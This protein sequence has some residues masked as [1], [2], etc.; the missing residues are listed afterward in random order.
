MVH[1]L[2]KGPSG[3]HLER[4][5]RRGYVHTAALAPEKPS[6]LVIAL[7]GAACGENKSIVE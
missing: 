3:L 1:Q 2:M 7:F 5:K 4:S 6:E